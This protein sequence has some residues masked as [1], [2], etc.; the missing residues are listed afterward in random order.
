MIIDV[1]RTSRTSWFQFF[2]PPVPLSAAELPSQPATSA[3]IGFFVGTA[4]LTRVRWY[5]A[6]EGA[7][8]LPGGTIFAGTDHNTLAENCE[9]VYGERPGF[10]N[11]RWNNGKAPAG[12]TGK[13]FCGTSF[14]FLHPQR[15]RSDLPCVQRGASGLLVCCNQ[16]MA[17]AI[18][19]TS[20]ASVVNQLVLTAHQ[21][22]VNKGSGLELLQVST[23]ESFLVLIPF[24][25]TLDRQQLEL[26]QTVSI[27]PPS[28]LELTSSVPAEA[29]LSLSTYVPEANFLVLTTPALPSSPL[30]LAGSQVDSAFVELT[31]VLGEPSSP[32]ALLSTEVR[33]SALELLAPDSAESCL[34]L[35]QA[36]GPELTPIE[37]AAKELQPGLLELSPLPISAGSLLEL[38]NIDAT[39]DYLVLDQVAITPGV[40]EMT[41]ANVLVQPLEFSHLFGTVDYLQFVYAQVFNGVGIML[42]GSAV[43][44]SPLVLAEVSLAVPWLELYPAIVQSGNDLELTSKFPY[45]DILIF[46]TAPA[47]FGGLLEL[48]PIPMPSG[49]IELMQVDRPEAFVEFAYLEGFVE[50]ME[51]LA[52]RVDRQELQL[53][54]PV[55][56]ADSL[57][58]IDAQVKPGI[59][60]LTA[61]LQTPTAQGVMMELDRGAYGM[62]AQCCPL[63]ESPALITV[64]VTAPGY[65][66]D[67]MTFPLE[68]HY[69]GGIVEWRGIDQSNAFGHGVAFVNSPDSTP[70]ELLVG[71]LWFRFSPF[72]IFEAIMFATAPIA[73]CNPWFFSYSVPIVLNGTP[74]GD[75]AIIALNSIP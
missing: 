11:R 16:F 43:V 65:D 26:A 37:F 48:S 69:T 35:V 18:G 14:D 32:M 54:N 42:T 6:P 44:T 62:N 73:S 1:G 2:D 39:P 75:D 49:P 36:A 38:A 50:A 13:E 74:T 15:W 56:P 52:Y 23:P 68:A 34:E 61:K 71:L 4:P 64:I 5:F 25:V 8:P 3:A 40:L 17:A 67:G 41:S 28:P 66:F 31:A 24:Q 70:G 22:F 10:E 20:P 30:E 57:A 59:L 12:A 45:P 47:V 58:L 27:V 46:E 7:R 9:V 72:A 19:W 29:F 63:A 33:F 21:V 60:A 51:L 55:V 53:A